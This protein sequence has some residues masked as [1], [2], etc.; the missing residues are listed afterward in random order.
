[1]RCLVT[2]G[3]GFIGSNIAL[4]LY[5]QGLEVIVTGNESEQ[6][7]P[8]GIKHFYPALYGIDW[9]SLFNGGKI[10]MLFHQAALNDTT[11][12]DSDEMM[13]ANHSTSSSLFYMLIKNG[14]RRIVYASSTAVYGDVPAPYTESGPVNPLNPYAK[15]KLSLDESAMK[16]AAES[17]AAIVGLR[18]CNVYGPGESHKGKRASMIYQ[19]AQQM[20]VGSPK[21][22]T[23][24][25]QKR[26]WIYVKDVVAAN[27]LASNPKES[28]IVNCG[29]GKATSFNDIVK[30]LGETMC[31]RRDVSYIDNP[32][33]NRYQ[34]YTECDMSLAKEK[35]GFVPKYSIKEGI[36]DFYETGFLVNR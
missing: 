21:L 35:I 32:Y 27:L 5:N 2:G 1:M 11:N 9:L 22:F 6:K 16:L 26:D 30:I 33:S 17:C 7:L 8:K 3:T 34:G 10:D 36:R 4:E 14:C 25:N 31:V 18:Y 23:D 19:L 15:S 20:R 28:C 12:L 29:S 24:G 13:F